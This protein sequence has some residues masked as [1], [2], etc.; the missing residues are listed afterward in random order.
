MRRF[1][2]AG[3]ALL[4]LGTR[5]ARC[6]IPANGIAPS[7]STRATRAC[8]G[9]GSR[10]GSTRTAARR[11]ISQPT[12]SIRPTC[13]SR[14]RRVRVRSTRRIARPSRA[15]ASRPRQGCGTRRTTSRCRCRIAKVSS[16]SRRGAATR[17]SR[18]GWISPASDCSPKNR[19]AGSSSTPRI[20]AAGKRSRG[21][22]SRFSWA[23]PSHMRRPTRTASCAGPLRSARASRSRS[24]ARARRSS[25][26]CRKHRSLQRSSA[27]ARSV[28]TCTRASGCAWSA[29][30]AGASAR[31]TVRRPAT[32]RS[33][34]WRAAGRWPRLP[35]G[36]TARVR[37]ARSSPC[38]PM[39]R[40]AMRASSPASVPPAAAR[41]CTWRASATS[42]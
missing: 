38:R 24:G 19:R 8:R 12:K 16:P 7:R 35:F 18:R 20:W 6:L 11:S 13:S 21:C 36:S 26:C 15:G 31:R 30:R 3:A 10:C 32:R 17:C 33:S 23:R 42:S 39:R 14:A 27:C 37:S 22:A 40:P 2:A 5:R 4:L 41:R 9:S 28:P 1:C 25:R 34:C 29:S